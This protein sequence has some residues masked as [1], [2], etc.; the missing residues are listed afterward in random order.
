MVKAI[1]KLSL[2]FN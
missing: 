2:Y 1:V